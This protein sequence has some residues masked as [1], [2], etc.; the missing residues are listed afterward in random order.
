MA[1][2]LGG[3]ET[4]ICIQAFLAWKYHFWETAFSHGEFINSATTVFASIDV[5]WG[6]STVKAQI[7]LVTDNFTSPNM[8]LFT[9]DTFT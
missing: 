9:N 2:I 3:R 1:S 4:I 8:K 7:F 6:K 5:G